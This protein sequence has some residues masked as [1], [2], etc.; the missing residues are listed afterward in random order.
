M[1]RLV[2]PFAA[3]LALTACGGEPRAPGP[4]P[5]VTLKLTAPNEGASVL[6]DKVEVRGTVSPAGA[7]VEVLGEPAQ[8]AKGSFTKVVALHAGANVIDVSAS[9]AGRRADVGVVRVLRDMRVRIPPLLGLDHVDAEDQLTRL[10]L[11]FEEQ[12]GGSFLDK[13]IPGGALQVCESQPPQGTLVDPHS[14][15]TLVVAHNC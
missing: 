9:V 6:A 14:S 3:A 4:E 5:R 13:I 8:V 15:V 7:A 11:D 12:R 2:L 10:G 1:R